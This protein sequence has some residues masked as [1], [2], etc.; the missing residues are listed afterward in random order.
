MA[1][2]LEVLSQAISLPVD[3]LKLRSSGTDQE[4]EQHLAELSK[5]GLVEIKQVHLGGLSA[6][7]GKVDIVELTSKGYRAAVK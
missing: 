5:D 4:V 2:V 3:E 7:L 6:K 1:G